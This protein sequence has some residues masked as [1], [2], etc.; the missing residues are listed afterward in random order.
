MS[1]VLNKPGDGRSAS[2]QIM[3]GVYTVVDHEYDAWHQ[4]PVRLSQLSTLMSHFVV[5]SARKTHDSIA[6]ADERQQFLKHLRDE[7]R[8][9]VLSPLGNHQQ[10]EKNEN[11]NKERKEHE[12]NDDEDNDNTE[13]SSSSSSSLSSNGSNN[14]KRRASM[15]VIDFPVK[16]SQGTLES[17]TQEEERN[18]FKQHL[19]QSLQQ[20]F[21][22]VTIALTTTQ[23]G[24]VP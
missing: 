14:R 21:I 17:I 24:Q 11:K 15:T 20:E 12:Q 16:T 8:S 7:M 9:E 22:P 1:T 5:E 3:E 2:K 6:D 4:L 10:K 13:D 23:G 18:A 19:H